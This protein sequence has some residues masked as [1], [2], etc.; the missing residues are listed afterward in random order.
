MVGHT[1][2]NAPITSDCAK[3]QVLR[4]LDGQ[5]LDTELVYPNEDETIEKL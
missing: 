3:V 1:F 4:V 2:H 5:Y